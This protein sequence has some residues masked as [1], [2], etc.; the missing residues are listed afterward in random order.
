MRKVK[1]L[2]A[3]IA[4]GGLVGCATYGRAIPQKSSLTYGMA[5]KEINRLE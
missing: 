3:L 4:S 1:L 2:T 5:K